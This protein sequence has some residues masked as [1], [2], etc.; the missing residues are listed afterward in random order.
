MKFLAACVQMNSGGDLQENLQAAE[1]LCRDAA[2]RGARVVVLPE[3]FPL[4]AAD[5]TL[6]QTIAEADG[7]SEGVIQNC[8]STIAKTNEIILIGGTIPLRAADENDARVYSSC[9]VYSSAGERL[10]RYDKIHLFH[11]MGQ[12]QSFA[13]SK[14]II[15]GDSV[16]VVETQLD[17]APL[18]I[19]LSVCYDLRFPELYRRMG[20][21]DMLAAPS[22]FTCE[23]GAKHWQLLLQARAV[24]NQTY[25]LGAAQT[26][27][28]AGGRSTYGHSMV[29]DAWGEVCA[30]SQT[31]APEVVTAELDLQKTEAIR[32][33][34]PALQNRQL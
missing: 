3:F 32:A 22:A 14:T 12:Q 30:H 9:L 24:E 29:V 1:A 5:E 19:G 6:K 28:H 11:F 7:D 27:T 34:L 17:D 15:A 2:E 4:L 18:R 23:T 21:V 31:D 26:G 25:V 20:A 13:E 33:R 16:V 8:L 10:A